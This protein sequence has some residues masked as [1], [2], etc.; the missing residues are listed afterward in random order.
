MEKKY[1]IKYYTKDQLRQRH[2]C[3]RA[4]I[5]PKTVA[6]A[7]DT[8]RAAMYALSS[9]TPDVGHIICAPEIVESA[10]SKAKVQYKIGWYDDAGKRKY[11]L[12]ETKAEALEFIERLIDY[13]G[14][15]SIKRITSLGLGNDGILE[16]E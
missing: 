1:L 14:Q 11:V 5:S 9:S 4:Y 13:P 6:V 12:V 3:P 10:E 16:E 2:N 15:V 7:A 8:V